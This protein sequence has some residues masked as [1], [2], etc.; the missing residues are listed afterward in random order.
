MTTMTTKTIAKPVPVIPEGQIRTLPRCH[1]PHWLVIA[2][3]LPLL[4]SCC[5]TPPPVSRHFDRHSAQGAARYLRYAVEARQFEE[6]YAC[7][8]PT[9]RERLSYGAFKWGLRIWQPEQLDGLSVLEFVEQA[10][11]FP[12]LDEPAMVGPRSHGIVFA[13]VPADGDVVEQTLTFREIDGV[14]YY[15]LETLRGVTF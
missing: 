3:L 7:L 2:S 8:L 1:W 15:D 13:Y 11:L 5:V 14:W 9:L 12:H 6:A 4:G 10:Q